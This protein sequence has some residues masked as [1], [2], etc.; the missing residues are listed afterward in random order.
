M[1][2]QTTSFTMKAVSGF[3]GFFNVLPIRAIKILLKI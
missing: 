3:R 2:M 1:E